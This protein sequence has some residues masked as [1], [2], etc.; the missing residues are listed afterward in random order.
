MTFRYIG[1]KARIVAEIIEALG[2]PTSRG[3]R[4]VDLFCGTGAVAEGA[5]RAGWD[6][7]LNDHLHC[8][9]IMAA[10]RILGSENARFEAT[11][12][13]KKTIDCLN[14]LAGESGFIYRSYSPASTREIGFERRYFTKENAGRI[15]AI[16]RRIDDWK[17]DG[18][19]SDCEEQ[20]LIAD[21]LSAANRVANIAGT[22]GCFLSIWQKQ[23][24][25]ALSMKPRPLLPGEVRVSLS[26][27]EAERVRTRPSDVVYLD[28][29]YTKRQYAAYYHL[30][31]TIALGDAPVVSGVAGIRPWQQKAS[32]FCYKTKAM[33][34]FTTLIGG[35]EAERVL[36]S[37]SDNAHVPIEN[38]SDGIASFG[39]A[40]P[41]MLTEIGRYRP[42]RIASGRRATVNE[43]LIELERT[44][45]QAA[46]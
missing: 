28:P 16:R 2:P 46:A 19:I 34:A 15:D 39:Q 25:G 10:S 17:K 45:L 5:V 26:V 7:H 30:L 31:E 9:V 22:Y 37:Y 1:S 24:L 29:P 41:T 14:A 23:A 12:G 42:N 20:L 4:F 3:G 33:R 13:Y 6:V 36:V 38:L 40:T 21:L 44:A 8:A 27:M 43:Y 18:A 32:D 11:G 35:L